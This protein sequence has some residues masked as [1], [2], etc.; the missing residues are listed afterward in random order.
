M[1]EWSG[2]QL[3]ADL[4]QRNSWLFQ[5]R[6]VLCPFFVGIGL[7]VKR[8]CVEDSDHM[9]LRGALEYAADTVNC[10][11]RQSVDESVQ[12]SL[13][14]VGTLPPASPP[15]CSSACSAAKK[16]SAPFIWSNFGCSAGGQR[17]QMRW[18]SYSNAGDK[19]C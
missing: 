4:V 6:G 7:V 1:A 15:G 8:S 5:R 10:L 19:P 9:V 18:L 17:S 11:V 16:C 3:A 2:Q 14:H 13:G 12:I